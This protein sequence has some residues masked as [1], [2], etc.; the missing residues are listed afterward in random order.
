MLQKHAAHM[1]TAGRNRVA[2]GDDI[3]KALA[4][5]PFTFFAAASASLS[6]TTGTLLT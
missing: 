4:N 5:L 3:A 6:R 1:Y 2:P